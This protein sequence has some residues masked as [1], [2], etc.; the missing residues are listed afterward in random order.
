MNVAN[1]QEHVPR[2][3]RNN[4]VIKER[5]RS[6]FFPARHGISKYYSPRMIVHH[7]SLD[8]SKHC[9]YS[10][11]TYVRGHDEPDPSN[12]NDP[13]S[14]DCIDLAYNPNQQGGH[15]LLHLPTGRR[16]IRRNITLIP[17]TPSIIRQVHSMAE[18]DGITEGLKISNRY[19]EVLFDSTWIAGVD[20][21]EHEFD[22]DDYSTDDDEDDDEDDSD[23]GEDDYEQVDPNEV[24]DVLEEAQPQQ[25]EQAQPNPEP[26]GDDDSED[27]DSDDEESDDNDDNDESNPRTAEDNNTDEGGHVARSGRVS[28]APSRMNL[29]NV[30]DPDNPSNQGEI[31]YSRRSASVLAYVMN[32]V[33]EITQTEYAFLQTYSLN[34]GIKKFGQRGKDAANKEMRQLHDRKVFEPIDVNELTGQKNAT[35]QWRA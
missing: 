9:K 10:Y 32:H 24:T 1:P 7:E 17:I 5:V 4:R 25:Q 23:F 8:Y 30:A 16:I 27:D 20:Y 19:G 11:G 29:F 34:A 31:Q 15:I 33:A 14:L 26:E 3:E 28:K 18:E 12:T 22:D 13:R 35:E 6:V 2:A 21:N